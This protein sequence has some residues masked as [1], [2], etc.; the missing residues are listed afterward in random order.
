MARG[1]AFDPSCIGTER[2]EEGHSRATIPEFD[3]ALLQD[4]HGEIQTSS[5][6]KIDAVPIEEE[7]TSHGVRV[8]AASH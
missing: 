2:E 7:G 8:Y 1:V 5:K 4:E 3:M 6:S